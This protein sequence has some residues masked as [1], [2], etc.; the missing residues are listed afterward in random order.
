MLVTLEDRVRTVTAI[1]ED[2]DGEGYARALMLLVYD[3]ANEG[4]PFAE[5]WETVTKVLDEQ[6]EERN[7][8]R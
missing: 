3:A 2:R 8:R 4:V 1:D 6:R 7:A 5:A